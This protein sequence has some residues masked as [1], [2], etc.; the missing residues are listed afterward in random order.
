M[1]HCT[2]RRKSQVPIR[3]CIPS[4]GVKSYIEPSGAD[5]F[6]IATSP[7][8]SRLKLMHAMMY[9]AGAGDPSAAQVHPSIPRRVQRPSSRKP[10]GR[11]TESHPC[12]EPIRPDA[13]QLYPDPRWSASEK[14]KPKVAQR[15]DKKSEGKHGLFSRSPPR[16]GEKR[17]AT[18]K[19]EEEP[20]SCHQRI[21]RGRRIQLYRALRATAE[22]RGRLMVQQWLAWRRVQFIHRAKTPLP[23]GI[24]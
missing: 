6:R 9:H 2:W 11:A 19:A 22:D 23:V 7:A 8:T 14:R 10:K 16:K 12:K 18:P 3:F 13:E 1:R 4:R 15:G 5:R 20:K 17:P 21:V 24:Q